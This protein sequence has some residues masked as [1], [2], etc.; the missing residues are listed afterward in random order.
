VVAIH[1]ARRHRGL[2]SLLPL[3]Q[4]YSDAAAI[5]AAATSVMLLIKTKRV[6]AAMMRMRLRQFFDELAG[7]L[8]R[9]QRAHRDSVRSLKTQMEAMQQQ[10]ALHRGEALAARAAP[11][12]VAA[13]PAE[14]PVA[15]A[16]RVA[17]ARAAVVRNAPAPPAKVAVRRQ[18]QRA[19]SSSESSESSASES[20]EDDTP[21]RR[22]P[23]GR[24][25]AVAPRPLAERIAD[26]AL[27]RQTRPPAKGKKK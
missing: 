10:M 4:P 5:E 2:W 12:A 20:S 14:A 21:L 13:A 23:R 11:A 16:A 6:T 3:E 27:A 26:V 1:F 24:P 7:N 9:R 15:P 19:P 18:Q 22:R 25:A 8:S 17:V